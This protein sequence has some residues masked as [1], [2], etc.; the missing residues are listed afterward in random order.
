MILT[1]LGIPMTLFGLFIALVNLSKRQRAIGR[2]VIR[3]AGAREAKDVSVVGIAR[4]ITA[5]GKSPVLG[6]Q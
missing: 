3:P 4:S 5:T 1:I 2:N 6:R